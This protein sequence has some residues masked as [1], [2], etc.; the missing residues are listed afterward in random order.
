MIKFCTICN[1]SR[2]RHDI[3]QPYP[4]NECRCDGF[5]YVPQQNIFYFTFGQSHPLRDNWIEIKASS[6]EAAREKMNQVFGHHWAFQYRSNNFDRD[7]F[8]GGKAGRT[9][10]A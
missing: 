9:I 8:R 2:E 7:F 5:S 4:C 1:H 3:E 10:E 6:P